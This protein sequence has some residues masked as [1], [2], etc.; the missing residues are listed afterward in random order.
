MIDEAR[1]LPAALEAAWMVAG[2]ETT[3]REVAWIVAGFLRHLLAD[4]DAMRR[5]AEHADTGASTTTPDD[6]RAALLAAVQVPG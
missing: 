4:D 2:D 1:L 5:L 6:A 3:E